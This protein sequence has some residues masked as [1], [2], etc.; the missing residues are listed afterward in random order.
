MSKVFF[1]II[2][3]IY[4]AADYLEDCINSILEQSEKNYEIILI[5]DAS[6]DNS[7]T[8][9]KIYNDAHENINLIDNS[10]C[11]GV[12]YSRN[13]GISVAAGQY[14]IFVDSDDYILPNTLS[15]SLNLIVK[16]GRPDLVILG[17]NRDDGESDLCKLFN[18]CPKKTDEFIKLIPFSSNNL[19]K[20][21][22]SEFILFFENE[23]LEIISL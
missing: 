3:P 18:E 5:N 20:S 11:K 22:T 19:I 8:I 4:N 1:S 17:Y 23:Y 9:C 6:S 16:C 10:E 15:C 7:L 2:I 13:M 21:F 14:I 12:S